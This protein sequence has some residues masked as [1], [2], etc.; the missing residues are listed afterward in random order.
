[1]LA[2]DQIDSSNAKSHAVSI[3][4]FVRMRYPLDILPL[5]WNIGIMHLLSTINKIVIAWLVIDKHSHHYNQKTA[6][7]AEQIF[8]R[9]PILSNESPTHLVKETDL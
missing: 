5:T 9:D 7:V 6:V 8:K 2:T 3:K 4:A 1:M